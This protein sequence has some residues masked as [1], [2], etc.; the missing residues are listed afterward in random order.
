MEWPISLPSS[1]LRNVVSLSR[2]FPFPNLI[3]NISISIRENSRY[4]I[5]KL[6][7]RESR[8]RCHC[9]TSALIR[10][11]SRDAQA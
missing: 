6:V 10:L 1:C 5:A 4:H 9:S 11:V 7:L 8:R 3:N 2:S